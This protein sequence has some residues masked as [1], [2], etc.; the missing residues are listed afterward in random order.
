MRASRSRSRNGHGF[1]VVFD[2]SCFRAYFDQ[3]LEPFCGEPRTTT[4]PARHTSCSVQNLES[5]AEPGGLCRTFT[6]LQF[7]KSATPILAQSSVIHGERLV[8][9]DGRHWVGG[10]EGGSGL[11]TAGSRPKFG[12]MGRGNGTALSEGGTKEKKVLRYAQFKS[13]PFQRRY[14]K[15][16]VNHRPD[17][18]GCGFRVLGSRVS[19]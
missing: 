7:A 16:Q 4:P 15:I 1:K 6:R 5:S 8:F 19:G 12:G 9:Q 10:I 3:P 17:P 14:A 11:K 13:D 18:L 2:Q